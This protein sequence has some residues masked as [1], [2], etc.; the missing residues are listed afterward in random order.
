MLRPIAPGWL[1]GAMEK[2]ARISLSAVGSNPE[3]RG[4][5]FWAW[6]VERP[7]PEDELK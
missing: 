7:T 6:G 4:G 5:N 2:D 1:A 3:V